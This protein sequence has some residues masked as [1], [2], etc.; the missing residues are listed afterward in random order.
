MRQA[1]GWTGK[2]FAHGI[3]VALAALLVSGVVAWVALLLS[4]E[5]ATSKQKARPGITQNQARFDSWPNGISAWTVVLAS[6]ESK[7]LAESAV[8][9]AK[10]IAS[11]GLNIGILRS[12]D[13]ASL[14]PGYWVAFAG[15]FD[16]VDEAQQ[17]AD[18]YRSQFS[19]AYQRFI[20]E[21]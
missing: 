12:A 16:S 21:R 17:A 1:L 6:E 8:E 10:R 3:L 9:R 11:R 15:Q 13:Y 5:K 7:G 4:E 2:N 14:R 19:S 20:E 18:R